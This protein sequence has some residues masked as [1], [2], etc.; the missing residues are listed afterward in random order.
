MAKKKSIGEETVVISESATKA[1]STETVY[2]FKI[3]LLRV[4]PPIWRRIQIDD[5]T[6]DELH[7]HVQTS[8]G[9][10]NSHLHQFKIGEQLYAD[11]MLM[12][13]DFEE[14]GCQD[15]TTT[16]LSD[17]IPETHK[18]LRFQYEYD[19]GDRWKHAILFEGFPQVEVATEYPLCLE[20]E[21]ACPPEDVGGV[22]GY[23]DFLKAIR[24]MNRP[25]Q[26]PCQA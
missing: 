2:Q 19:F 10:T 6:L 18:R 11:P 21:R 3:T 14:F 5:C 4:K 24:A 12:E 8:M 17:I 26:S 16:M 22:S 1:K 25:R 15:S 7:E 13:E 23:A 20:G 9:W